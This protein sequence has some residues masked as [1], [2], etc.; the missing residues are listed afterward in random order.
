MRS[1]IA[2]G[3]A[4][5]DPWP[6]R[7]RNL[8]ALAADASIRPA[9]SVVS[10]MAMRVFLQATRQTSATAARTSSRTVTPAVESEFS[11]QPL[12]SGRAAIFTPHNDRSHPRLSKK[13]QFIPAAHHVVAT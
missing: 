7:S 10:P 9:V 13:S 11:Q 5:T 2:R 3:F 1:S 4:S 12:S 8:D 6:S